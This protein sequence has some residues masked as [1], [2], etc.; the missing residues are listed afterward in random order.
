[1][2]GETHHMWFIKR[3]IYIFKSEFIVK[4]KLQSFSIHNI[5]KL[6]LH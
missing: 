4:S 1:M 3:L 6:D 2:L 5:L